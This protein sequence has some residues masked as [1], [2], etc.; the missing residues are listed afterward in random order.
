MSETHTVEFQKHIVNNSKE[1]NNG[2]D[3]AWAALKTARESARLSGR[4][5]ARTT[6]REHSMAEAWT[7]C[8]RDRHRRAAPLHC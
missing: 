4:L 2:P 7:R 3:V 6:G 8:L 1:I 5:S